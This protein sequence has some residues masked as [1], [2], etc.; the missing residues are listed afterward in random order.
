MS[1]VAEPIVLSKL[2]SYS[3]QK[4]GVVTKNTPQ[5]PHPSPCTQK[6]AGGVLCVTDSLDS[7]RSKGK[8][9]GAHFRAA[10]HAVEPN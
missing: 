1:K 10:L 2:S 7:F 8:E 9:V 3:K 4:D 6:N 5:V